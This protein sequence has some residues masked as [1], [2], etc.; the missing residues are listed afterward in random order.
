M[1]AWALRRESNRPMQHQIS[2]GSQ[3]LLG[4]SVLGVNPLRPG[5]SPPFIQTSP[6]L[7]SVTRLGGGGAAWVQVPP[8]GVFSHWSSLSSGGPVPWNLT[9]SGPAPGS[10]ELVAGR[11]RSQSFHSQQKAPCECSLSCQLVFF[12]EH[13]IDLNTDIFPSRPSAR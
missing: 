8:K 13:R 4:G 7:Q 6:P 11:M 9:A 5:L 1:E 10:L 12:K 3:P 2:G